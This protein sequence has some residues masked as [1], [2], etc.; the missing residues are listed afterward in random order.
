MRVDLATEA[1]RLARALAELMPDEPEALGLLALL[2]LTDARRPARVAPDGSMV[3]LHE[4]DRSRWDRAMID[5]GLALVRACRRR[6]RPGPYQVQAAIAGVHAEAATAADTDWARIVA[7]YDLLLALRPSPV[8]ALNRAVAVAER[9]GPA[10]GLAALEAIDAAPLERYQPLH[11]VRA[12]LLARVGRTDE[13]RQAYD[14]AIEL[15]ANAVEARFLAT[16]RAA[17]T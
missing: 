14:R 5:E 17:L 10:A 9:D 11:A 6:A 7:L 12:D 16:R 2:L 8:V 15:S 13:A 3:P 1:I 4:Q